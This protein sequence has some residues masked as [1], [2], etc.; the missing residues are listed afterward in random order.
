MTVASV[1]LRRG[2]DRRLRAGHRWVYSN[3]L[4]HP[5]PPVE[6]GALVQIEDH[7]G[8]FLATAAYH[9]HA[10]IAARIW[11]RDPS[12]QVDEQL[13]TRRLAAAA[14]RR[15]ALA[16]DWQAH[17][18][19]HAEADD[20]PGLV[21]DRYGTLAVVQGTSAFTDTMVPF[22]ASQLHEHHGCKT[23]ILRNDARGR[24]IEGLPSE[25]R[26]L[27][28]S[29]DGPISVEEGGV[30]IRFDPLGGQKTGL[31]LDMRTNRDRM[32]RWAADRT[33]LDL[34][35]YVGAVGARAAAAGAR[36]VTC[37]D[38]SAGACAFARDNVA[39]GQ[40]IQADVRDHLKEV[41][42]ATY[43]LVV[44][45]PPAMIQRKRDVARGVDA[46][47]RLLYLAMRAVAPAGLLVS[48]SCSYHLTADKHVEVVEGAA[49][50]QGR[51]L[52]RV[53]RGGAGPDHPLL[54]AH[55]QTD[56]LDCLV[57]LV[58]GHPRGG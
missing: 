39:G 6:A 50:R 48:A 7:R 23:V 44:C 26:V 14:A 42:P 43:D 31:Y 46:L 33:V 58:E 8:R 13:V 27:S 49:A 4:V 19:V 54:P 56:Y 21:V 28:G 18:M 35:S 10:L 36:S 40:V 47:R 55:P 53:F 2:R 38:S 45:D 34:Y 32:A 22:V 9:P 29:L 25:V 1:A 52:R 24:Q 12:E 41:A 5:D 11:T 20:L 30:E 17:R 3:E 57:Y 16:P 51:T 37:V 15:A